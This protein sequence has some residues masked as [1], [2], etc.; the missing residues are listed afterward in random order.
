M[1]GTRIAK[2]V[3]KHTPTYRRHAGRPR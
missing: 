1:S 2:L 3:Y